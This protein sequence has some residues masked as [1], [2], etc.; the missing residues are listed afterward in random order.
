MRRTI[1]PF[2]VVA[3]ACGSAPPSPPGSAV[4]VA[5][6][7]AT[8][9][10]QRVPRTFEAGGVV[11]AATTATLASRITAPVLSMRV[12][13]G[14]RV[15]AGQVLVVFDGRDLEAN[16]A[17]AAAEVMVLERAQTGAAA[18]R[19]VAEAELTL[20]RT[21]QS[22]VARLLAHD[23][24]TPQQLDESNSALAVAEA[25]VTAADAHAAASAAS[26]EGA[27]QAAAAARAT[28][29][30]ATLT[31]PFDGLITERLVDAGALAQPGAPLLRIDDTRRFRLEVVVDESRLASIADGGHVE[32]TLDANDAEEASATPL[33]GTISEIARSLD[34]GSHSF[35]VKVDLPSIPAV[36]SGMFGRARFAAGAEDRLTISPAAIVPRGQLSTI[37]VVS[38]DT[39]AQ[40]RVIDVGARGPDWVEVLAGVSADERVILSPVGIADGA[41]VKMSG[42]DRR[43]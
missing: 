17:R 10:R 26:L 28:A 40:M 2:L 3:A 8:V 43:R 21:S 38:P 20:A 14:D 5:V 37:Y 6:R 15:R 19:A 34:A 1:I 42:A 23:A 31:A 22:R 24:A 30:Y 27:R 13:A 33:N 4:P 16:H 41:V 29:T 32:V 11:R 18:D 25:H 35:T 39:R 9:A 12:A 7:T 36:R